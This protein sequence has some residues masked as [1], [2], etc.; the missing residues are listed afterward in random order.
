MLGAYY[1]NQQGKEIKFLDA[2]DIYTEAGKK[3]MIGNTLYDMNIPDIGHVVGFENHSGK[4][5]LNGD[6]KPLAKVIK[7]YGNNGEDKTE[8]AMYKNVFCSYSH[9]ALLPKNPKLADHILKTTL[10]QKYGK[11]INMEKLDDSLENKAHDSV[12]KMVIGSKA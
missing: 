11:D 6:V 12:E 3:R 4:T 7:G 10:N 1:K 9:G 5:F 8:G 2:I